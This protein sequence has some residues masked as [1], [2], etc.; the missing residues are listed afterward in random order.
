MG[1]RQEAGLIECLHFGQL[2][3]KISPIPS[4]ERAS[5]TQMHRILDASP[6]GSSELPGLVVFPSDKR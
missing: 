1:D 4:N 2:S 5:G 6:P 3:G